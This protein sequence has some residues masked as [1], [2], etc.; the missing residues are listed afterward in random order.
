MALTREQFQQV[1]AIMQATL[2]QTLAAAVVSV[3]TNDRPGGGDKFTG[4]EDE[5]KAWEFDF[6]VST[7]AADANLVEAMEVAE[8]ESK[9]ITAANFS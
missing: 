5:W 1:M 4:F 6:K 3:A 8:I 9:D 7:R 2:Q